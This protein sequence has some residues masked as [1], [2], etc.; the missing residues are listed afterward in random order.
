MWIFSVPSADF[1]TMA[2][3]Q[4]LSLSLL[5]VLTLPSSG[6]WIGRLVVDPAL[7]VEVEGW[8]EPS[9]GA[10]AGIRTGAPLD[11]LGVDVPGGAPASRQA[12]RH[13]DRQ[14][15]GHGR[16]TQGARRPPGDG[17]HGPAG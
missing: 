5:T 17:G 16:P 11:A 1:H 4:P 3:P 2:L 12:H 13:D 7:P 9:E 10:V 6:A 15:R 14:G 8:A